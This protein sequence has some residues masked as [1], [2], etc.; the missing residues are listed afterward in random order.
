MD[1]P[2]LLSDIRQQQKRRVGSKQG[3]KEGANAGKKGV[4]QSSY[5]S[6]GPAIAL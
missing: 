5:K 6:V 3:F 1:D 2:W 4:E